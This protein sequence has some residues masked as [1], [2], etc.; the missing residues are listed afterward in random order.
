MAKERKFYNPKQKADY[1][2][3]QLKSGKDKDGKDLTKRQKAFRAGYLK[4]Y[5]NSV[6]AYKSQQKKK[7]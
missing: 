4:S 1:Y 6:G 2:G 5:H 7:K 3:N